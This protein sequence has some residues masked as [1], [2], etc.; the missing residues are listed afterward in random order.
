MPLYPNDKIQ[1]E[2]DSSDPAIKKNMSTRIMELVSPIGK[3]QRA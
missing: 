1:L 2:M 3:G